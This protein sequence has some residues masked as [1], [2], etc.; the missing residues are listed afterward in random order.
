MTLF[1]LSKWRNLLRVSGRSRKEFDFPGTAA[2]GRLRNGI[3]TFKGST[4]TDD[5]T[6]TA[7]D[8]G[9]QN[10]RSV[11]TKTGVDTLLQEGF[12]RQKNGNGKRSRSNDS[13]GAANATKHMP[14]LESAIRLAN[15]HPTPGV[16]HCGTP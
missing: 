5:F 1:R 16:T 6:L 3:V 14:G 9:V 2:D 12:F 11:T 8:G 13:S 7:L 10:G 15:Q 4:M